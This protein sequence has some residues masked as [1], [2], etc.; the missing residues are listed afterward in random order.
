METKDNYPDFFP[1]VN[2]GFG[3]TNEIPL[4][5]SYSR[6]IVRP[7]ITQLNP[8]TQ[9]RNSFFILD[10]NANLKPEYIDSY[11]IEP[12]LF[13]TYVSLYY[14]NTKN[15]IMSVSEVT[16]NNVEHRTYQNVGKKTEY[17]ISIYRSFQISQLGQVTL[18]GGYSKKKIE[19]NYSG[20]NLYTSESNWYTN[21]FTSINLGWG[22][23]VYFSMY[24]WSPFSGWT[25]L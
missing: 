11:S 7:D 18:S 23:G 22:A 21:F 14:R 16:I 15:H 24:Y 25:K 6:R 5:L 12:G 2:I 3:L 20:Q 10:G 17:G 9:I 4:N 8:F 13:G 1:S 19:G